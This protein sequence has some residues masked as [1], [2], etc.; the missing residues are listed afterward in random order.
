MTAS[1]SGRRMLTEHCIR[2]S[3]YKDGKGD[4]VGEMAARHAPR[5]AR[6]R[7]LSLALG[8]QPRRIWPPGLCRLFPQADRRT[9]HA[10]RRR[11]SNSGSTARTAATAITAARARRGRSTRRPITTGRRSSR[12]STSISRWRAPSTRSARTCA[13]S[14]TRTAS[15][16]IRAGRPCRTIPM[17]SP[18]AIRACAVRRSGGPP[19][20]TSRSA[21][22]GSITPTRTR[23]SRRPRA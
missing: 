23:R 9:L 7:P 14:A 22:A 21:P 19:R 17:S 13:G 12:W 20:P 6:L 3:P 8:P 18:R 5:R 2:N 16:A 1:A 10:L 11:C 4:I 15:P